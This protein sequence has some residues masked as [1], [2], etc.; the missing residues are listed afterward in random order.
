MR[1]RTVPYSARSYSRQLLWRSH[2]R[3]PLLSSIWA[4]ESIVKGTLP[5]QKLTWISPGCARYLTSHHR[6]E[7]LQ[8]GKMVKTSV[9]NDALNSINNAEKAGKRQV[10]I[11]P[12]SKVIVKF[13]SVMQKHGTF[14]ESTDGF[15][16]NFH[17]R[18]LFSGL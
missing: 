16:A 2:L 14:F 3:Y 7:N 9:L 8:F 17:N 18:T 12:S 5:A 15:I 10:L 4:E 11:R 6:V 13:L 1:F